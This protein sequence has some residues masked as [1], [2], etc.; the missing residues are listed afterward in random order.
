MS[1]TS[2]HQD[3]ALRQLIH[4]FG[5]RLVGTRSVKHLVAEALLLLPEETVQYVLRHCWILSSSDDAWAYA[6]SGDDVAGQ[7]LIFLSD[8][9]FEQS[10]E[11][12]I[13]TIVHE[14][15]HVMLKHRNSIGH[16]QTK[17][18]IERQEQQADQFAHRFLN[19]SPSLSRSLRDKEER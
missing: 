14:I 19:A 17:K 11:Q 1:P 7:H 6:F 15:G 10:K 18:E 4:L 12:I 16:H 9:L 2:P 5:G 8:E 13:Y 3:L